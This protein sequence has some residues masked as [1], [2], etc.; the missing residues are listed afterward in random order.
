MANGSKDRMHIS[1]NGL[2]FAKLSEQAKREGVSVSYIVERDSA[3][4]LGVAPPKPR[5]GWRT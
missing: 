1:V 4:H 5:K 3:P 2:Y